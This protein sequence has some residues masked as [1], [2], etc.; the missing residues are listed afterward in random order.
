MLLRKSLSFHDLIIRFWK[1]YALINVF[2]FKIA[3]FDNLL[4]LLNKQN[5]T[6]GECTG[7]GVIG[8]HLPLSLLNWTHR[9]YERR[10]MNF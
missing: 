5:P 10:L 3:Y 9:R 6:N 7:N 1:E 4:L 8:R 2:Y